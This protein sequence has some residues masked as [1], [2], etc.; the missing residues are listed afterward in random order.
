M[1]KKGWMTKDMFDSY[2]KDVWAPY[3]KQFQRTLLIMDKFAVHCMPE[4]IS[5]LNSVNTDVL[6]IPGGLT[7]LLQPL[8]VY[9]NK[10]MKDRMRECFNSFING[11]QLQL[12]KS[13]NISN[14]NLRPN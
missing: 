10:P 11:E 4:V 6:F 13:S 7:H 1:Q 3:A 5:K 2:F 14:K 9:A 8:D 12:T